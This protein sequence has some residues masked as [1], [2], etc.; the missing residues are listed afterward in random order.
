M[1][2]TK[3]APESLIGSARA[4]VTVQYKGMQISLSLLQNQL[5]VLLSNSKRH[6]SHQ[7]MQQ[8]HTSDPRKEVQYLRRKGIS[9]QD[10]WVEATREVPRHKLYFINPKECSNE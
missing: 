4:S 2:K 10:V 9:V 8:L 1:A 3:Q 5:F 6:S 7:L